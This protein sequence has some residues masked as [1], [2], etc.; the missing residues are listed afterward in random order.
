[1]YLV[2]QTDKNQQEKIIGCIDNENDFELAI[3]DYLELLKQSY[4]IVGNVT[5]NLIN[6]NNKYAEGHYLLSENKKYILVQKNKKIS[7][8]Y[9]YNSTY[10]ET[11]I[12]YNWKLLPYEFA[13]K[14]KPYFLNNITEFDFFKM[15]PKPSILI[16]NKRGLGK[17][18]IVRDFMIRLRNISDQPNF[19]ENSLIISPTERFN[20][21]YE[22][23]CPSAK[24]LYKYDSNIVMEYLE[25]GK[26]CI[27]IDD[28]FSSSDHGNIDFCIKDYN[29]PIII[30]SHTPHVLDQNFSHEIDY[31]YF[32]EEDSICSKKIIW[33]YFSNIIPSWHNFDTTLKYLT[34][35]HMGMIIDNTNMSNDVT[36]KIF[37]YKA[38][39][40]IDGE[41][42]QN[43]DNN[44]NTIY[45]THINPH[46]DED[47]I[48][49]MLAV[50]N[51]DDDQ[52][53]H[54]YNSNLDKSLDIS[55]DS[56]LDSSI[57]MDKSCYFVQGGIL[58]LGLDD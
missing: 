8:G 19:F 54:L 16:Y 20:K 29:I 36:S 56:S 31:L 12:I 52:D 45:G 50:E 3:T 23:F 55:T 22:Y 14:P 7:L 40:V 57:D 27:I 51:D 39:A 38:K 11:Q 6:S 25:R 4:I 41:I 46:D 42:V 24:I 15:K 47:L 58:H 26:G 10:Y 48:L 18:Y 5:P 35:N 49:T 2:H 32:S 28:C 13:I 37:Y 53:N 17:T 34:R 21:F 9:L 44:T 33:S 43:D 1:M 30:T